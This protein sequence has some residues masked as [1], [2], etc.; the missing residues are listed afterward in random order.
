VNPGL[1]DIWYR[2]KRLNKPGPQKRTEE[3]ENELRELFQRVD[4]EQPLMKWLYE[5]CLRRRRRQERSH[6]F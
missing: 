1:F 5:E 2:G 3:T 6:V 4:L